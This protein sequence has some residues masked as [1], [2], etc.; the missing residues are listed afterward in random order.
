MQRV[1]LHG[2]FMHQEVN[3]RSD[4]VLS[5]MARLKSEMEIENG[6]FVYIGRI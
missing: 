5:I 2:V 3:L 6:E 1:P 4:R